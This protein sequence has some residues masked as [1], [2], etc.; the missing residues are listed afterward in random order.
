MPITHAIATD[1]PLIRVRIWGTITADELTTHYERLAGDPAFDPSF[2]QLT[3]V[4]ELDYLD[5]SARAVQSAAESRIFFRGVRRAILVATDYQEAA[6][7]TFASYASDVEQLVEV[8]RD[9]AA[10]EQWLQL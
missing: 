2:W 6:A 1:R 5:A 10:A 7:R 3:D 8:F 4:R 9:S